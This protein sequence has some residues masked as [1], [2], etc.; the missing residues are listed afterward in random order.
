MTSRPSSAPI[1]SEGW[2]AYFDLGDRDRNHTSRKAGTRG[3]LRGKDRAESFA[4][5]SGNAICQLNGGRWDRIYDHHIA[6]DRNRGNIARNCMTLDGAEELPLHYGTPHSDQITLR[7]LAFSIASASVE[8]PSFARAFETR[9]VTSS[10]DKPSSTAMSRR[11]FLSAA[12][13]KHVTSHTEILIAP[14]LARRVTRT[15]GAPRRNQFELSS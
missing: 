14:P 2:T 12:Q 4:A 3:T 6:A 1:S 8:A 7:S 13:R 5:P 9:K 10:S 11:L 15:I